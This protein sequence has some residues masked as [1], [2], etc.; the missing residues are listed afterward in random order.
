MSRW[1]AVLTVLAACSSQDHTHVTCDD[2]SW[3]DPMA[4]G[5]MTS[6]FDA[7]PH[8]TCEAE[9]KI[10]PAPLPPPYNATGACSVE[11]TVSQPPV[12][13]GQNAAPAY[14]TPFCTSS[15]E[16]R[17]WTFSAGQ[18]YIDD[19][20]EAPDVV[21]APCVLSMSNTNGVDPCSQ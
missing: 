3:S 9:V 17:G 7:F 20:T 10:L 15:H 8:A 5:W 12:R 2:A 13:A 1:F 19:G 16:Y 21:S 6:S 4:V 14:W 11:A 18:Y